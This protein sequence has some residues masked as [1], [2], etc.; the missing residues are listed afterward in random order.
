[1]D[2]LKNVMNFTSVQLFTAELP[3]GWL[4]VTKSDAPTTY[5]NATLLLEILASN[6]IGFYSQPKFLI[7]FPITR[8]LHIP[9]SFSYVALRKIDKKLHF[10]RQYTAGVR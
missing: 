5:T 9:E 10:Y 4:T 7:K 8:L 2:L 6:V 1:V 3:S